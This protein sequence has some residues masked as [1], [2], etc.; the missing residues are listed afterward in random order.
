M[1]RCSIKKKKES[2]LD[3][4]IFQEYVSLFYY[5][6]RIIFIFF[7]IQIQ[8]LY[9]L[10]GS[11]KDFLLQFYLIPF[12]LDVVQFKCNLFV[13]ISSP[14]Y[15]SFFDF[16]LLQKN[17]L[18]NIFSFLCFNLADF[19]LLQKNLLV[20]IFSFLCF[21]LADLILL[22]SD[23]HAIIIFSL[24]NNFFIIIRYNGDQFSG[25]L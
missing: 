17:L 7:C 23:L 25:G 5:L 10:P 22:R 20:N 16:I 11:L 12:P 18:I 3:P 19:I 24:F 4:I 13:S 1:N 14:L 8:F 21:N 15:F 9:P 2:I 6:F